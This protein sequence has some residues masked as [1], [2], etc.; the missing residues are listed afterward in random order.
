[1]SSSFVRN[2]VSF[3]PSLLR[4]LISATALGMFL[5][6]SV[7][8]AQLHVGL[9]YFL[10]VERL[11]YSDAPWRT[12]VKCAYSSCTLIQTCYEGSNFSLFI[13]LVLPCFPTSL[14]SRAVWLGRL[15]P[16]QIC[17]YI[18]SLKRLAD[19]D[20]VLLI[21]TLTLF[22]RGPCKKLQRPTYPELNVGNRYGKHVTGQQLHQLN[23]VYL[24]WSLHYTSVTTTFQ[25]YITAIS[26][27]SANIR[28]GRFVLHHVLF[29]YP[30]KVDFHTPWRF[31]GGFDVLTYMQIIKLKVFCIF[32]YFTWRLMRH[33]LNVSLL[34]ACP[35]L[36]TLEF[37]RSDVL[38]C[39]RTCIDGTADSNNDWI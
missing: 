10:Y 20:D 36:V 13:H 39:F 30:V 17:I 37:P 14:Q 21:I 3:T 9:R 33:C 27:C 1:M 5:I 35:W 25:Y 8:I 31:W 38:F 12:A 15:I 24:P 29:H 7:N 16:H 18:Y 11:Q 19:L 2:H 28:C 23:K 32:Y 22:T 34:T 26:D 6:L 4:M